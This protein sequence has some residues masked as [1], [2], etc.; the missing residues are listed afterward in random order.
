MF[1]RLALFVSV[2]LYSLNVF[3]QDYTIPDYTEIEKLTKDKTSAFYY[4]NLFNRYQ[5]NDTTLELRDYRML[6]FGYF[7]QPSYAPF[8]HTP[9]S[10]SIKMILGNNETLTNDE[11]KNV[12]NIG[13]RNLKKNPFDLKGLNIV[14]VAY[15]QTGDS[16][17]A[18][19]YF[20]KLK[21]LV[22]TILSTG[23]GLS[24]KTAIHVLN[25][26]H[27][28]DILNILGYE[29]AGNQN[30]TQN[31]CDFLS[32]KTNNDKIAGLYF[33]VNQIFKGYQKSLTNKEP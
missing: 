1:R 18:R 8:Y 13:R 19:S 16:V 27:E 12:I 23:D 7:F 6:Y 28:Y 21:K 5:Q 15:R 3:S 4:D 30:L 32:L 31:K 29:F 14:W 25:V 24:E 17:I 26:S 9:E 22:H 33:D 11:W 2:L 20:D 10:D